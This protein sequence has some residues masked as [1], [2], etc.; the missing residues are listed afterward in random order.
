MPVKLAD[1]K[2]NM[3][4]LHRFVL[5]NGIKMSGRSKLSGEIRF[6]NVHV[7][8]N[9]LNIHIAYNPLTLLL[10]I[11]PTEMKTYMHTKT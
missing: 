5:I 4:L 8:L 1:G 3:L 10:A 9:T 7:F 6:L 2:C 11:C